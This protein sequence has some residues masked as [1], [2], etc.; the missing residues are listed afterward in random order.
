MLIGLS[1]SR[2]IADIV[3]GT[4]DIND[5]LVLISRTDFD[6][7]NDEQWKGIWDGY[8]EKYGL[9]DP[10]WI[11]YPDDSE[12]KFRGV[13]LRLLKSGKFHQPR[14]FG[15]FPP[16]RGEYWLKVVL[17]N[18]ELERNAAA[19]EAWEQFQLVAGLTNISLNDS[20]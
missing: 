20:I 19:K 2:C 1:Y 11:D 6:P 16:R 10:H 4:V 7:E 8:R 3:D 5:V 17:P 13:T 14:K 15:A 18:S 12:D 9:S